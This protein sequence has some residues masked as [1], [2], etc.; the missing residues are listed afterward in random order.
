MTSSYKG[1]KVKLEPKDEYDTMEEQQK[2]GKGK[3]V[4]DHPMKNVTR[5]SKKI[6]IKSKTLPKSSLKND[7]SIDLEN[8]PFEAE[9]KSKFD[10]FLEIELE[11]Y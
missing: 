5:A 8:N 1:K 6:S 2:D 4:A 9:I 7:Y 10:C 3:H 11:D